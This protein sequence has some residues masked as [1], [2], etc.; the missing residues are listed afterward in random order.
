MLIRNQV[1]KGQ[2]GSLPPKREIKKIKKKGL[3]GVLE[4]G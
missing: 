4:V 1:N 3:R 2:E